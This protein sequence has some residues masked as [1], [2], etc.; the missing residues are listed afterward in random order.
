MCGSR[1]SPGV[2]TATL[3][4]LSLLPRFDAFNIKKNSERFGPTEMF[5]HSSVCE[6][7]FPEGGKGDEHESHIVAIENVPT[8]YINGAIQVVHGDVADQP[9]G[10]TRYQRSL[11]FV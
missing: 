8:S 7:R 6:T 4:L 9:R 2:S 10:N 3:I 1:A 11:L 5:G